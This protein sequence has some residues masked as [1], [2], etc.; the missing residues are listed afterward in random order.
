M[1]PL[2]KK[3]RWTRFSRF[4]VL[5]LALGLAA[6]AAGYL[7]TR[8]LGGGEAIQ[9]M[10]LGCALSLVGSLIGSLPVLAASARAREVG[11]RELL[12]SLGVRF[13]VVAGGATAM[14]L[15]GVVSPRPF[16]VWVALSHFIFLIADV[17]YS[18]GEQRAAA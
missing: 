13:F 12:G 15:S 8:N 6:A 4:V 17:T 7:P 2:P 18:V 5:L 9:A 14:A 3:S 11:A 10:L 16:L 1:K